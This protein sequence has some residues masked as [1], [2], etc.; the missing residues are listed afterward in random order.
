[1]RGDH[2]L[3]PIREIVNGALSALSYAAGVGRPSIPPE[4]LLR[5]LLPSGLYGIR[6]ERQAKERL[7][8]SAGSWAARLTRV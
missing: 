1:M 3:R 7:E 5:A 2:P 4:R 6:S 8:C